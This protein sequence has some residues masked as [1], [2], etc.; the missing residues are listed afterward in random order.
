MIGPSDL[1]F[2]L[3]SFISFFLLPSLSSSFPLS[4]SLFPFF[5]PFRL[6]FFSSFFPL[7]A[8]LLPYLFPLSPSLLIFSPFSPS[9][10]PLSL[11]LLSFSLFFPFHPPSLLSFFPLGESDRVRSLY[12]RLL[13]RTSHVKVW[14]S[15]GQFEASEAKT[16]IDVPVITGNVIK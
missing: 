16:L 3:S 14:M 2:L 8:P 13:E 4:P 10:I 15:Y 5:L 6:P 12:S 1:S 7:S 9:F 11:F